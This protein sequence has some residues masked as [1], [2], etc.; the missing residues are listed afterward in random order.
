MLAKPS[1]VRL[2]RSDAISDQTCKQAVPRKLLDSTL[3]LKADDAKKRLHLQ[4]YSL[5]YIYFRTISSEYVVITACF[6]SKYAWYLS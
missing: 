5:R 6:R 4:K 1:R 3:T 2:V